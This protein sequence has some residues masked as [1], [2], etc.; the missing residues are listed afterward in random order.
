MLLINAA[1]ASSAWHRLPPSLPPTSDQNHI[2]PP[3]LREMLRWITLENSHM[4][5]HVLPICPRRMATQATVKDVPAD[6]F[7]AQLAAHLKKK[8]DVPQWA[9]LVKTAPYKEMCPQDP[10]W[11]FIRA[12]SLAR[13]IY[14]RGG[15][16]VG[17]FTKVYG[18]RAS[19]G[20]RNA[21]FGR[22]ARGCIRHALTQLKKLK[23]IDEKK[24]KK[25][26][27]FCR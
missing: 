8:M 2:Q 21:D 12:A 27:G 11:F 20:V 26:V 23:I 1:F 24:D 18:G 17:A 3:R 10:D 19:H 16:G 22:A 4:P 5:Q 7:I 9:D 13:R 25:Y 15:N 14:I 6:K